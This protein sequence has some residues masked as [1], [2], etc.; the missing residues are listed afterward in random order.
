VIYNGYF[1]AVKAAAA[2]IAATLAALALAATAGASQLITRN[3]VHPRL[4]VNAHGEALVTYSRYGATQ[5]VLAW[6]AINA[7]KPT[8]GLRQE[9]FHLDYSGGWHTHH[10]IYWRTFRNACRPYTGP[11]LAFFVAGCDAPDGSYWALQSWQMMLPDL[12]FKPWTSLQ[13]SWDLHLAHWTGP[14]AQLSVYTDWIYGGRFH[15]LFGKYMYA[16]TPVYGF[17]TTHFGAPTDGYGRLVYLDTYNSR[18]GPGWRRENSFVSHNPTGMWCYGFYPFHV[19]D[20]PHP[21][22]LTGDAT[23]GPGNGAQYRLSASGPGV[24]P[25][26]SVVVPGLHDYNP[27]NPAD[28]AYERQQN[29]IL[30]SIVGVDKLCRQH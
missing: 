9:R 6:G 8:A 18:Y 15:D 26:V 14:L 22:G 1:V 24:T 17:G 5:R 2:V 11:P 28:V 23:R 10:T 7:H 20:Y 3:A 4:A 13:R 21:R 12:G 30:D 25:D 16:G 19:K 29:A 27:S